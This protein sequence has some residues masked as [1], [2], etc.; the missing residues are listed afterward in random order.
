MSIKCKHLVVGAGAVGLACARKLALKGSTILIDRNPTFGQETSSR[1]SQVI[2]SGIYYP[3]ESLKT[4]LCIKGQR[5]LYEYIN[6]KRIPYNKC[7]KW[8]CAKASEIPQLLKIKERAD[9]LGVGVYLQ[10]RLKCMELEPN[11]RADLALVVPETGIFDSHMYMQA[12][13]SDFIASEGIVSYRSDL[14]SVRKQGFEF[15]STVKSDKEHFLIESDVVIN[16]CGLN[17]HNISKFS[18]KDVQMY[19]AKGHYYSTKERLCSRLIY[20]IPDSNLTSLGLHLTL[21]LDGTCKFGPDVYYQEKVDY[22]PNDID[23]K[24]VRREIGRYLRNIP[25]DLRMDYTG[26]RPKLAK[27]GEAFRDF[28]I[29]NID[30]FVN[31]LGI[32]S[33]GLTASLAIGDYVS[34][35]I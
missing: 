10:S 3:P 22:T 34:D 33:P 20:P 6:A 13:E 15:I 17:A 28:E 32:E 18:G 31:L 8:V 29:E 9:G 27:P 5:L 23:I 24:Q 12:M 25:R 4:K 35:L 14:L 11:V 30:G 2:H 21:N 19:F 16:A 7:G 26:I 1:N